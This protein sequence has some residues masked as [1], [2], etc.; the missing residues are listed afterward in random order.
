MII[1]VRIAGRVKQKKKDLETMN[2]LKIRK[3][4]SA[5][6][7]DEKDKVRMGMVEAAGSCL[8]YGPIGDGLIKK[9]KPM[10]KNGVYFLHPPRGG[11][12]K[13]S[14]LAYPRGILGKNSE[15]SLMVERMLKE[16]PQKKKKQEEAKSK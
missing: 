7:V 14:K 1:A 15:I 6:L 13:S 3:K 10:E 5:I 4:F 9:L 16:P 11:F 8:A 2:R 12:K